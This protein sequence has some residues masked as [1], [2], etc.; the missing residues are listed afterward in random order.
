MNDRDRKI[1]EDQVFWYIKTFDQY[2][3]HMPILK[4]FEYDDGGVAKMSKK[5]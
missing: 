1:K 2:Y 3:D 5:N 4:W